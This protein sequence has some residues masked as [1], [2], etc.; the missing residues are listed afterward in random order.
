MTQTIQSNEEK[1]FHVIAQLICSGDRHI[2]RYK[3]ANMVPSVSRPTVY[4]I[5]NKYKE[6]QCQ[7]Q[8]Q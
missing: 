1:V 3:I 2:T 5:L 8:N 6:K 4:N 7:L